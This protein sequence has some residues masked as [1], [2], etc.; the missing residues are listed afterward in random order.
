MRTRSFHSKELVKLLKRKKIATMDELKVTL[1]TDVNITVYRKL[2]EVSYHTSYSH[3]GRYY[4][5]DEVAGFDDKGL[6]SFRDVWFSRY[7]NLLTTAEVFVKGSKAGYFAKELEN[8]LNVGVKETL[9]N[10]VRQGRISRKKV[11]GLYLYC[12]PARDRIHEQLLSRQMRETE[13]SL[14]R[15]VAATEMLPDEL[16]AAI[17][18]FFSLLNEKQRRLYAGLESLKWGHG[19]DRKIADLF[20]LDVRT[21]AKGR[22]D[23]LGQGVEPERIRRPGGGRKSTKKNI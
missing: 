14:T 5:L 6:W 23:L 12:A 15:S 1:G 13:P 20:G 18:L 11:S 9:L 22:H 7:G 19:G 21:V 10:L 16:R 8:V 4:T 17:V 3:R 2:R